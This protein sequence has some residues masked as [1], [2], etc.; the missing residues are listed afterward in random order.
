MCVCALYS[1]IQQCTFFVH[2]CVSLCVYVNVCVCVCVCV[3]GTQGTQIHLQEHVEA[4]KI[5]VRRLKAELDKKRIE[6][7]KT[8]LLYIDQAPVTQ[9]LLETCSL[10]CALTTSGALSG[11]A[12]RPQKN[13]FQPMSYYSPKRA[14]VRL[15]VMGACSLLPGVQIFNALRAPR[16]QSWYMELS[17]L[18][19]GG[20]SMK[21]KRSK[22]WTPRDFSSRT[23]LARLVLWISG[24]VVVS[25]SFL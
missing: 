10:L 9:Q 24:M 19:S 23:T 13:L 22:S 5:E 12:A 1:Q 8:Q 14:G 25:I 3:F 11:R 2:M 7:E 21:W 15:G 17:M 16:I 4:Q 20:G 18:S 6:G